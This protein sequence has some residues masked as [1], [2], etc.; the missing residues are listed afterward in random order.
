MRSASPPATPPSPAARRW[1]E[2]TESPLPLECGKNWIHNRITLAPTKWGRGQGEGDGFADSNGEAQVAGAT[3]SAGAHHAP[4]TTLRREAAVGGT[5]RSQA[6]RLQV[7][8]A[9]SD[10]QLHRRQRLFA[11]K[12]DRRAGWRR[13]HAKTG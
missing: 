12:T 3:Q 6:R 10:R 4:G 13:S 7:Q 5:A 2:R 8:T 11:G 9:A 1:G